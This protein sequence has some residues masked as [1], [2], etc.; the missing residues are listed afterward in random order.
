M[1]GRQLVCRK[2]IAG[3]VLLITSLSLPLAKADG[4]DFDTGN[5]AI[6]L[7]IPRI[8]PI[9]PQSISPSGG[10]ATLVLRTTTLITNVWFDAIAP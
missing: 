3:I 8:I 2:T 7:V 10:D 1:L 5:A 9:I 6:E 4:Y